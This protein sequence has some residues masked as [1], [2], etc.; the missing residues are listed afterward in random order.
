VAL[1]K[2]R[3]SGRGSSK[4]RSDK[5]FAESDV[6]SEA[7]DTVDMMS[8]K[9]DR[10]G[11]RRGERSYQRSGSNVS[12]SL[13]EK[14]QRRTDEDGQQI[15]S[16]TNDRSERDRPPPPKRA[17]SQDGLDKYADDADCVVSL[18]DDENSTKG[19]VI[20]TSPNNKKKDS[21]KNESLA[22]NSMQS[23]DC[24]S[25]ES[26]S[27]RKSSTAHANNI[28]RKQN[29][30]RPSE[31]LLRSRHESACRYLRMGQFDQALRKFEDVRGALE[32]YYGH[33]HHRVGACLHNIGIVHLRAGN[34]DESMTS[35]EEA[36][37]IRKQTLGDFHSKVA[38]SLVEL[39]IILLS[40]REFSDA[41]DVFNE[42]LELRERERAKS[43]HDEDENLIDNK[44]AKVLNNLGCVHYEY[45][46]L[47]EAIVTFE[48]ALEIQR[49]VIGDGD[50]GTEPGCLA[51]ASTM[52]NIGYVYL[53]GRKFEE[54]IV[55]ME[56]AN[57]ILQ[58]ILEPENKL[59][60]NT[61]DNLGYAYAKSGNY[62]AALKNYE[63]KYMNEVEI[64]SHGSTQLEIAD[65]L[66][67]M[68]Y[69]H[70]K[71][72]NHEKAL[73]ALTKAEQIQAEH[74]PPDSRKLTKTR[75][76]IGIVKYQILKFP[77]MN[78][79]FFRL[80]TRTGIRN[81]F[82]NGLC[83]CS[84]ASPALEEDD[85]EQHILKRPQ[86]SSKMSGHKVTYA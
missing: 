79:L 16:P 58:A 10:S 19:S 23:I 80:I 66:R 47:N 76:L 40:K 29:S 6:G 11:S 67:K 50:P 64:N 39:G 48:E 7:G 9:S 5:W 57:E 4:G 62:D 1:K 37:K 22:V 42:A 56:E 61:L 21:S 31:K 78:E 59:V 33:Q 36:V 52:C 77:G 30:S 53:E 68:G 84:C 71:L 63:E 28:S 81:P 14:S 32:D 54:A 86:N 12:E 72:T 13:F 17:D 38:D 25:Q 85:I 24:L 69:C 26:E 49:D 2:K 65:S 15:A 45:G 46:D 35:L 74:L 83:E 51:M 60:L 75:E 82:D 70:L 55:I 34:L 73:E 41:Q 43:K 18:A 3:T 27:P 8:M 44:V 20:V